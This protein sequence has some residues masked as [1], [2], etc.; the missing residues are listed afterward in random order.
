MNMKRKFIVSALTALILVCVCA[1]SGC[2]GKTV[3]DL[4]DYVSVDF[5]GYNGDGSASVTIDANA[6]LPLIE[7]QNSPETIA[8]NFT[9]A[10]IKNNG[11]LSNGDKINVTVKFSE[12]LMENAKISVQNPTHSFTVSGLKEKEKLD[13][14]AGVEFTSSGTSPECT[15][16]VKYNG[17]SPY[18]KLELQT[19]NGE[20]LKDNFDKRYFKNNEKVTLRIS[21]T[22]LEQLRA[23]YIIEETSR[24]YIVKTDSSY[25]LTAADLTDEHRKSL[26]KIAEDFV[27]DKIKE[28]V[29][30]ADRSSRYELLSQLSG[31]NVGKFYA[32]TTN[33][34]DKLEITTLNSVYIGGEKQIY[35]FYDADISYY[36]KDFFTVY[37]DKKTCTLIVRVNGSKIT[38]EGVMYSGLDFGS[39]KEF[40]AAYN[41]FI[42]SEFEKLP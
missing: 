34:I 33:R 32:G 20:I 4:T 11:K 6:M 3:I 5:S 22:A 17:G 24:D 7:D 15:A 28:V 19:E 2:S 39:R 18:G 38:P 1:L 12:K 13:V 25:I 21:E 10:E 23:E 42:T 31:L 41:D 26:D 35:Y 37:N 29:N 8:G 27:N 16:S 36:I 30:A 40:E 14:F 9:V